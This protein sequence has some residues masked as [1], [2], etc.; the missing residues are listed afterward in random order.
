[1]PSLFYP[2]QQDTDHDIALAD[3][4]GQLKTSGD[5][6]KLFSKDEQSMGRFMRDMRRPTDLVFQLD[7][8]GRICRAAWFQPFTIGAL[9]SIWLRED[10][11]H[12]TSALKF[13]YEVLDHATRTWPV[14]VGITKQPDLLDAHRNLGY[15]I[16]EPI[17]NAWDG[18]PA[19]FLTLTRAGFEEARHGRKQ[20]SATQHIE[21]TGGTIQEPVRHLEP[22]PTIPSG[23]GETT[24]RD[25]RDLTNDPDAHHAAEQCEVGLQQVD[26]LPQRQPRP[27]STRR[28]ALRTAPK[29]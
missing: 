16:S 26:D 6:D 23:P 17:P 15:T 19:W 18:E 7:A 2:Y 25:R 10:S 20:S 28:H 27:K 22:A 11:R 9:T 4:W 5:L 13:V 3:W 1:M 8:G 21:G 12:S 29:I 24:R 14:L